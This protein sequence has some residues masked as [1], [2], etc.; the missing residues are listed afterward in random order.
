MGGFEGRGD[1]TRRRN[2]ADL[3]SQTSR[4][5]IDETINDIGKNGGVKSGDGGASS[6]PF[7]GTGTFERSATTPKTATIDK[8]GTVR[9][10][11]TSGGD[12]TGDG[13]ST[14]ARS[15][16]TG[17][18]VTPDN[19]EI[20]PLERRDQPDGEVR[21]L[22]RRNEPGAE[23]KPATP[24]SPS[25]GEV[26]DVPKR[27]Q[28]TP[29][30]SN[31]EL[32]NEASTASRPIPD[33]SGAGNRD[34]RP[35]DRQAPD[36]NNG[37]S[38]DVRPLERQASDSNPSR[39]QSVKAEAT[40]KT[41]V[42]NPAGG[43]NRD[44]QVI[45]PNPPR[46]NARENL[47]PKE[48]GQQTPMPRNQEMAAGRENALQQ[49]EM[50]QQSAGR[51]GQP[52]KDASNSRSVTEQA[53]GGT[54]RER[55]QQRLDNQQRAGGEVSG[56][57]R[58]VKSP[59][60]LAGDISTSPKREDSQRRPND[61]TA[62]EN[63][64]VR[65]RTNMD[66]FRPSTESG[67][68]AMENPK[69]KDLVLSSPFKPIE[70][71]EN[72]RRSREDTRVTAGD[73]T[74]LFRASIER[75][76]DRFIA[77]NPSA[78]SPI[79]LEGYISR[80]VRMEAPSISEVRSR[81][82]ASL[83]TTESKSIAAIKIPEGISRLDAK[84]ANK[85]D[86]VTKPADNQPAKGSRD[87]HAAGQPSD[88]RRV[89]PGRTTTGPRVIDQTN[90]RPPAGDGRVP[91][92]VPP[93]R[94]GVDSSA[95]VKTGDTGV[96]NPTQ[97]NDTIRT[98]HPD[99][100][101]LTGA[102]IAIAA[103]MVSAA[104]ARRRPEDAGRTDKQPAQQP[105]LRTGEKPTVKD[106]TQPT[107]V[108]SLDQATTLE[109]EIKSDAD[110]Q[111]LDHSLQTNAAEMEPEVKGEQDAPAESAVVIPL[112]TLLLEDSVDEEREMTEE[113]AKDPDAGSKQTLFKR[114]TYMIQD[115]DS[116]VSIAEANYHD[117]KVGWLIADMNEAQ[118]SQTYEGSK[119]IVEIRGRCEL[120]MPVW[121]DLVA[122]YNEDRSEAEPD[123]LITIVS[124]SA[125]DHEL[126]ESTLAVLLGAHENPLASK[127]SHAALAMDIFKVQNSSKISELRDR[128][129]RLNAQ[130][131]QR[132]MVGLT[133]RASA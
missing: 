99:R 86:P 59:T 74:Q 31:S 53:Q 107:S 58:E 109:P 130:T 32:R 69:V 15:T 4:T 88:A 36:V 85:F 64:G 98:L 116:L 115:G 104:I 92:P 62:A 61:T 121:E 73:G 93:I 51:D 87:V 95:G 10:Q 101:E 131:L 57:A 96:R 16:E 26:R 123:D 22:E 63:S 72:V 37:G 129:P 1:E 133:R 54:D 106:E 68:R 12:S 97:R 113:V 50:V 27:D 94:A 102:E 56:S 79:K 5:L 125:I 2:D 47:Q 83:A 46:E 119:R 29:Q 39:D 65:Q 18:P 25:G 108:V 120:E 48:P 132:L 23:L 6:D 89:E 33:S 52:A 105:E 127:T 60:N 14:P 111:E 43:Q 34:V 28:P 80:S 118:I 38:R 90:V 117:P 78:E 103:M 9:A 70:N 126:V 122:F 71:S 91:N 8:D 128:L 45:N 13:A 11:P 19:G 66:M 40:P 20:R 21:P 24:G 67:I 44:A 30:G 75:A 49:R 110:K 35:L 114:P 112:P 81:I 41:N 77:K 100:R 3:N 76:V 42:E 82:S 17:K 84:P 7:Q 124:S 55:Q